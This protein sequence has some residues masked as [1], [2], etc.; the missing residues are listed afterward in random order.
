M[1][2]EIKNGLTVAALPAEVEDAL[3]ALSKKGEDSVKDIKESAKSEINGESSTEHN[4]EKSSD[5]A[6]TT[7]E[8]P[9]VE[10]TK[11][12]AVEEP[13]AISKDIPEEAKTEK[14][15]GETTADAA[16]EEPEDNAVEAC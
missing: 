12:K 16:S 4:D 2:D 11:D 5:D 7:K 13:A 3:A 14:V 9:S 8:A 1:T 6:P 15:V 10:D